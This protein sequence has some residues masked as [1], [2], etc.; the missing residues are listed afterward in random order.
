MPQYCFRCASK[1]HPE[2]KERSFSA[3]VYIE[4]GDL[5]KGLVPDHHPCPV[6]GMMAPRAMEDEIPT[7]SL[8][9]LKPLSES[10][11][12]KGSLYHAA[13][14]AFGGGHVIGRDG[15]PVLKTSGEFQKFLDGANELGPPKVDDEGRPLRR[16][17]GS[18]IREGEKFVK[19]DRQATPPSSP[20]RPSR[21]VVTGFPGMSHSTVPDAFIGANDLPI[22]IEG[23][24]S[25]RHRA[26]PEVVSI[27]GK[28]QR[29][30]FPVPVHISPKRLPRKG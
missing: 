6:C 25:R 11:T 27:L 16:P 8:V 3:F 2:G 29:G 28:T 13:K 21:A 15:K 12:G 26:A 7:Q 17:D 18:V 24:Q 1:R 20:S 19:I 10:T 14:F 9:G 23:R 22:R 5:K 30:Q 4:P